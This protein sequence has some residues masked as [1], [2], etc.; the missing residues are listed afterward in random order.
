MTSD[1][2]YTWKIV[3]IG[4]PNVGKTSLIH[5]Y[6][7]NK[8]QETYNETIGI[9]LFTHTFTINNFEVN[10]LI[11]DLGGQSFWK[12]LRTDF[13]NRAKGIMLVYDVSRP[14]TFTNLPSWLDEAFDAIGHHVPC[15]VVGN[16]IDI[17]NSIPQEK[18]NDIMT[19]LNYKHNFTSAKTGDSVINSFKQLSE[20]IFNS[21]SSDV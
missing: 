17:N 3:V 10:L 12:K 14:E 5:R 19:K 9:D 15:I 8:F 11:Y 18:F 1:S 21:D 16:K 13:Y 2:S 4:D 20:E 6:I 7:D